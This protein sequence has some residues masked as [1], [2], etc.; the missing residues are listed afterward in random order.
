MDVELDDRAVLEADDAVA[1]GLQKV[2]DNIDVER[3]GVAFFV[4]EP[5]EAFTEE[6]GVYTMIYDGREHPLHAI[7]VPDDINEVIVTGY[8]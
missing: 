4:L 6:N 7:A 1:D 3:R 5:D 8:T 2:F